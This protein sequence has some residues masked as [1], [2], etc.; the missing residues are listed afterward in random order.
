[1]FV[2]MRSHSCQ[3]APFTPWV[4]GVSLLTNCNFPVHSEKSGFHHVRYL[5]PHSNPT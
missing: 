1:M 5:F 3:Y 2:D 4:I